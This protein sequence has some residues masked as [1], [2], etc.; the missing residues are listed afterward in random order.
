MGT[1]QE[2]AKFLNNTENA[3]TVNGL[4][5]DIRDALMDYQVCMSDYSPK[6]HLISTPD[7]ITTRY[8]R[9]ELSAHCRSPPLACRLC[10][11]TEDRNQRT[12]LS[13]TQCITLSTLGIAV[14]IGR[15]A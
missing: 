3:Q 7:L 13:S 2:I 15:V 10:G 5:E 6:P 1:Q 4:V 11:L 12:L 14:G 8:L 9:K